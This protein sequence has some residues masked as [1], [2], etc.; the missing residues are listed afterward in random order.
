MSLLLTNLLLTHLMLA[1]LIIF[2]SEKAKN[3]PLH[4][5]LLIYRLFLT[6]CLSLSLFPSQ[7]LHIMIFASKKAKAAKDV[8]IKIYTAGILAALS[9]GI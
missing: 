3:E 7:L 4:H 1:Y 6:V 9:A 5:N 2:S 8:L